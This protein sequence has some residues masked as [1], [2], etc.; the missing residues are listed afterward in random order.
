MRLFMLLRNNNIIGLFRERNNA[1][2]LYQRINH[3]DCRC[4]INEIETDFEIHNEVVEVSRDTITVEEA[5][6][7]LSCSRSNVYKLLNTGEISSM[8]I[9]RRRKLL[10]KDVIRY[11]DTILSPKYRS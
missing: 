9:G 4:Y 1:E 7:M 6:G 10:R 3:K 11:R 8:R 5:A 2:D